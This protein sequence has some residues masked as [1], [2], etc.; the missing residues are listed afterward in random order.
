[1][2]IYIYIYRRI[3]TIVPRIVHT[4]NVYPQIEERCALFSECL[5]QSFIR[6]LGL[7]AEMATT[8]ATFSPAYHVHT[9]QSMAID[10]IP[11][12][13][14]CEQSAVARTRP[15][16][17]LPYGHESM[18]TPAGTEVAMVTGWTKCGCDVC[19]FPFSLR[20]SGECYSYRF[21]SLLFFGVSLALCVCFCLCCCCC[22]PALY[23]FRNYSKM[24]ICCWLAARGEPVQPAVGESEKAIE[25]VQ[26]FVIRVKPRRM[27]DIGEQR[28][29]ARKRESVSDL[30]VYVY[31]IIRCVVFFKWLQAVMERNLISV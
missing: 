29:R 13:I 4:T 6:C 14:E 8:T 17:A 18:Q 16:N 26:F 12:Q 23:R 2:Y 11:M 22:L 5:V 20:F 30:N 9:P 19:T 31:Y 25:N 7:R 10:A 21:V 1:M 28:Q 24:D 15:S 27:E 3:Y